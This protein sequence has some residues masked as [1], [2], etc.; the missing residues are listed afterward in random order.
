MQTAMRIPGGVVDTVQQAGGTVLV[1]QPGTVQVTA[2]HPAT[3]FKY[4]KP[5]S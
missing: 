1:E 3:P 2:L 4:A 5:V